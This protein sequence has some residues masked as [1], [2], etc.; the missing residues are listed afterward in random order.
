MEPSSS[1]PSA[2]TAAL[3]GTVIADRYRIDKLLGEGGMGAVYLAEHVLMRKRVALKLLHADMS[4][5]EEI[6]GRFKREAQAAARVSHPNVAAATDFG[7][8]ADG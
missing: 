1:D 2:A 5:D 6:L 4:G 7:Q 3:I 8:T